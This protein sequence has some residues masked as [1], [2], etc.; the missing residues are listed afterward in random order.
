MTF[1]R[2]SAC[3]LAGLFSAGCLNTAPSLAKASQKAAKNDAALAEES[4]ALTT[5]ALDALGHAPT[6]PPTTLAKTLLKQDQQ[7]EGLPVHRIDVEA[8]LAGQS[9]AITALTN[10]LNHTEALLDDREKLRNE[11]AEL[12]SRLVELGTKYE[13]EHNR[14]ILRRIYMSLGLGGSIAG[15]FALCFFF[16]PAIAIIGR[17][18]GIIVSWLPSLASWVGVVSVKA[19]DSTVR[20][21]EKAKEAIG[22]DQTVALETSL[23][24]SMDDSHKLLVRNRKA[25]IILP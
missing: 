20:G 6:N 1:G 22:K 10:R 12:N 21:I 24:K 25:S 9:A 11:I 5:G 4:R 15:L 13:Q 18:L 2:A 8:I 17:I 3:L 23:S 14:G 19:F 7:I 16:P